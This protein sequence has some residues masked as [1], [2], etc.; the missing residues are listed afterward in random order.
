MVECKHAKDVIIIY[1]LLTLLRFE[2][3]LRNIGGTVI[4]NFTCTNPGRNGINFSS[5]SIMVSLQKY[6]YP[7]MIN[8]NRYIVLLSHFKFHTWLYNSPK[9]TPGYISGN[10]EPLL[11]EIIVIFI[12]L[13]I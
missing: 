6:T 11:D 7:F 4:H 5:F 1:L 3:E 12:L 10:V 13:Y 9:Q 8:G 2:R